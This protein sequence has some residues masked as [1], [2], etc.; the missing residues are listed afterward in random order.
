MFDIL[1]KIDKNLADAQKVANFT[2]G[3]LCFIGLYSKK[4]YSNCELLFNCFHEEALPKI[5]GMLKLTILKAMN[6][7]QEIEIEKM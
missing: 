5:K 1:D 3:I 2:A 6:M 4:S 7:D